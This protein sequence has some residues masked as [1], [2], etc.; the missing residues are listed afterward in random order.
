MTTKLCVKKNK[1]IMKFYIIKLHNFVKY[2]EYA[3]RRDHFLSLIHVS[4]I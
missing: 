2:F 3:K 4:A 1:K